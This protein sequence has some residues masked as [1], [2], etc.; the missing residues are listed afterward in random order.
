MKT[1]ASFLDRLLIFKALLVMCLVSSCSL[2]PEPNCPDPPYF[3]FVA[4]DKHWQNFAVGTQWVF[5]NQQHQRRTYQISRVEHEEKR[6]ETLAHPYVKVLSYHDYWL[7]SWERIDS[8]SRAGYFLLR[9]IPVDKDPSQ[10][11]LAGEAYWDDY[12]GQH[13]D[14]GGVYTK[15]LNFGADLSTISFHAL[16]VRGVTYQ[17]VTSFQASALAIIRLQ[18]IYHAPQKTTQLDY[19]QEAGV[20]RFVTLNGDRWERLP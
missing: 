13:N 3:P 17:H 10:S 14:M 12:I 1:T 18:T 2:F 19:D 16:T 9:R 20:I 4:V 15:Y 8:A 7:M 5:E 6:P 11:I